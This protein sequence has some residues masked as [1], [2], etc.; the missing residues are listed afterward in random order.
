MP[1]SSTGTPTVAGYLV[2]S[3]SISHAPTP[4]PL[5]SVLLLVLDLAATRVSGRHA[6]SRPQ[7]AAAL[8]LPKVQYPRVP[9]LVVHDVF[10]GKYYIVVIIILTAI[11]KK[12]IINIPRV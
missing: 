11:L 6:S 12:L 3:S 5:F 1:A 7:F 4:T 2:P 8:F 10:L 9:L